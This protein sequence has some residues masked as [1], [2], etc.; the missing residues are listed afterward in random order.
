MTT[1]LE[2]DR[3]PGGAPGSDGLR[4]VAIRANLVPHEVLADR[5]ADVTRRRVLTALAAL[6]A[7]LA[8]AFGLSWWQTNAAR[9]DLSLEQRQATVLQTQTRSFAPL[10]TAQDA[11]TSVHAQLRRLLAGDL[12]WQRML[13]ALQSAAPKGVTLTQVSGGVTTPSGTGGSANGSTTVLAGTG[14]ATVGSLTVT[15]TAPDKTSVANYTDALGRTPGLGTPFLNSVTAG[16]R[17]VTFNLTVPITS[18]ALGG[19]WTPVAGQRTGGN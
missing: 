9:N 16:D 6:V 14:G 1:S 3:S 8:V 7:V 5:A 13:T 19:R 18:A 15:G 11:T 10:V 17:D 12:S 2:V 4:F